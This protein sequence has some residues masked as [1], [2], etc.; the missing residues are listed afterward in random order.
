MTVRSEPL[1]PR[2]GVLV[3]TFAVL[4]GM[5]YA[6]ALANWIALVVF[7]LVLLFILGADVNQMIRSWRGMPDPPSEP[8]ARET[9][10]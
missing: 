9:T 1:I 2:W 10:P 6:V 3:A 7:S 4:G 5:I 8:A